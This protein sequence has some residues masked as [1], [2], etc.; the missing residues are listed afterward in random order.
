[1]SKFV[2][3]L[4]LGLLIQ[5]HSISAQKLPSKAKSFPDD[6]NEQD[7][8]DLMYNYIDSPFVDIVWCGKDKNVVFILTEKNTVYRSVNDGFSNN[9]LTEHLEELGK[10]QLISSEHQVIVYRSP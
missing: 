8:I 5:A 6:P 10:S 2:Y 7:K 4:F 9:K 3:L 1:M